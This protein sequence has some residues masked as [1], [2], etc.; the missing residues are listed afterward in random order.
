[1]LQRGL[2]RENFGL[3]IMKR[4][5]L[6]GESDRTDEGLKR[7]LGLLGAKAL[8]YHPFEYWIVVPERDASAL[9]SVLKDS[10]LKAVLEDFPMARPGSFRG[11]R[12]RSAST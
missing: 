3:R 4:V 12:T 8:L 6:V 1:L 11:G 10:H 7:A 2:E 9:I 5:V